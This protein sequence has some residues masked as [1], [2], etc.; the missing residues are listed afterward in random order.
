MTQPDGRHPA[1]PAG[2]PPQEPYVS[3]AA[4]AVGTPV[5]GP[6][7]PRS[8]GLRLSRRQA[9]EA[10]LSTRIPGG[11]GA[12]PTPRRRRR[13]L[14]ADSRRAEGAAV[15]H[16]RPHPDRPLRGWRRR[17][18]QPVEVLSGPIPATEK[19]LAKTGLAIDDIGAFEVNEAFASVPLAWLAETG[20]DPKRPNPLGGA[21]ALGHP[22][23]ASG[24]ILLT[25]LVNHLRDHG[26]SKHARRR[27]PASASRPGPVAGLSTTAA[28]P[29]AA[30][31]GLASRPPKSAS[32]IPQ[33]PR[34]SG[35]TSARRLLR[36]RRAG[37]PG[38]GGGSRRPALGKGR[39]P[40]R[41]PTN[42]PGRAARRTAH[43]RRA[44]PRPGPA[45]GPCA[46]GR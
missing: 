5:T 40:G 6:P 46:G 36:V 33:G 38:R 23:G 17:R 14:P 24:A 22:L 35:E 10:A 31:S 20:A 1:I 25:R 16:A 41:H 28:T 39:S 21:I 4:R 44:P 43:R 27:R 42:G 7:A 32:P 29:S 11:A 19:L 3:P 2:R 13:L 18:F 45:R 12:W 9:V 8:L 15:W 37:Q 30:C 26:L 34:R